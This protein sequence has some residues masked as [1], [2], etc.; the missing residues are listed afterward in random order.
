MR[1]AYGLLFPLEARPSER[2][3]AARPVASG[4]A[5][6]PTEHRSSGSRPELMPGFNIPVDTDIFG[7]AAKRQASAFSFVASD[8]A[9]TRDRKPIALCPPLSRVPLGE[10]SPRSGADLRRASFDPVIC[11][12]DTLSRTRVRFID[13]SRLPIGPLPPASVLIVGE[14]EPWIGLKARVWARDFFYGVCDDVSM[15]R[16]ERR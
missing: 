2:F 7:F 3:G 13:S 4:L 8:L 11:D 12:A 6:P 1:T 10:G 16:V 9:G 14:G 15:M 5:W